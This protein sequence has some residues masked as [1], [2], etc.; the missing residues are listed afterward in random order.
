M[1]DSSPIRV[2][3]LGAGWF[4]SRRHCPDLKAADSVELAALC[5]RDEEKLKQMAEHFE[6]EHTFTE[7][8]EMLE[9]DLDA[10]VI[11]SPHSLHYE[12]GLAALDNDLHILMEKPLTLVPSEGRDLV[13]K[14]QEKNKVLLVAQNPPYWIHC[15]FLRQLVEA[16]VLGE[17]E[18]A[19][20]NWMGD[21]QAVFGA[22]PLPDKLPGVVPPTN[23]RRDPSLNGGGYFVDGG[24]HLICELL[25]ST[26]LKAVEATAI[27]DDAEWDLRCALSLRLD[28]GALANI[29]AAANSAIFTKRQRSHYFG[30]KA[31]L[32]FH[33]FPFDV[34]FQLDG[35]ESSHVP[36][37]KLPPAPNPVGNWID[38][39][40]SGI[41]PELDGETAVHI[42]E[43]LEA[44]YK[45]A[46]DGARVS[47][48]V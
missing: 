41:D 13:Q 23:F 28:N 29:S 33:G 17:I 16:G 2:G 19:Q 42:V 6:V 4:A 31:T 22:K 27:M 12:H 11:C 36:D 1:P 37:D 8:R 45:S 39:I 18:S 32:S 43:I 47:I 10:V 46:R 9:S 38:C 48:P 44:C 20:I 30:S 21:A 35:E 7:Y 24:S 34:F 15:R 26:G 40:K 5:R 25:W 3:V 14:A